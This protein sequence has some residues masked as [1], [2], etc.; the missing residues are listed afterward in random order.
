V[1]VPVS[2]CGHRE[3][4]VLIGAVERRRS[5]VAGRA[6]ARAVRGDVTW[7]GDEE[8]VDHIGALRSRYDVPL[9]GV[10]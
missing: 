7:L 2:R 8:L 9:G 1:I 3:A 10:A 5:A 6:L 4:G